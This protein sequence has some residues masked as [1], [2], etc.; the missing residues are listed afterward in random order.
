MTTPGTTTLAAT[1]LMMRAIVTGLG[2]ELAD[3]PGTVIAAAAR[4][5][6][7]LLFRSFGLDTAGIAPG[8]PILSEQANEKGPVLLQIVHIT[9]ALKGVTLDL[10]GRR[11][12]QADGEPPRL[13]VTEMQQ[14]LEPE[15]DRVR[16]TLG[17]RLEEGAVACAAATA[18]LIHKH[19][20]RLAP[21]AGFDIAALGFIEG[22]KT[23]PAPLAAPA[24]S[25]PDP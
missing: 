15:V 10:A 16:Q 4:M 8:T 20:T 9:L 2:T 24:R 21:E 13:T 1:G 17:L 6:G 23:V 22:L 7:T 14:R 19:A 25:L 18:T 11:G 12:R 3:H 5:A